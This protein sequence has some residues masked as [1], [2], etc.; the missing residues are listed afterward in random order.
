MILDENNV[1]TFG[2]FQG[3]TFSDVGKADL[4]NYIN[5]FRQKDAKDANVLLLMEKYKEL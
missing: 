3:Q 1:F 5:F 4:R 2:K